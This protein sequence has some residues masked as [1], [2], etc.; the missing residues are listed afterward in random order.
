MSGDAAV[1]LLTE[2]IEQVARSNADH[3]DAAEDAQ[4]AADR[5]WAYVVSGR[6]RVERLIVAISQVGG[7]ASTLLEGSSRVAGELR[8]MATTSPA[9]RR[10]LGLEAES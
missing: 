9:I 3:R 2:R 4:R 5:E 10:E 8:A 6:E 1:E 7:D